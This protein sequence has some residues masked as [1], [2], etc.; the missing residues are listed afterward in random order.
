M[1]GTWPCQGRIANGETCGDTR[2][3][4][5][6]CR[7]P[8]C[9]LS[10][11]IYQKNTMNEKTS[12]ETGKMAESTKSTQKAEVASKFDGGKVML[13]L[14]PWEAL[15]EIAKVLT[16]GAGKYG[17]HNWRG[18]GLSYSRLLGAALRHLSAWAMGEDRD[19]ETGLSHLA[20]AGCC[21]LFLLSYT[22]LSGAMAD[23]R[24]DRVKVA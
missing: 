17:A 20:H 7:D 11:E 22:L 19:K 8:E 6:Y 5:T 16:F 23:E 14:L 12:N 15:I 9:S 21:I 10:F 3:M 1:S 24:D 2:W 13:E 4:G 18:T